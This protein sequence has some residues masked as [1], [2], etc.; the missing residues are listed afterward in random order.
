MKFTIENIGKIKSATIEVKGLTIITGENSIG[1]SVIGKTIF[2]LVKSVTG[3]IE[4]FEDERYSEIYDILR[5]IESIFFSYQRKN[6]DKRILRR[7]INVHNVMRRFEQMNSK[8]P[9]PSLF[10]DKNYAL[11]PFLDYLTET[12]DKFLSSI[13][14]NEENII[15]EVKSDFNKIREIVKRPSDE[16]RMLKGSFNHLIQH[17]FNNEFGNK[18]NKEAR[19]NLI[20]SENDRELVRIEVKNNKTCIFKTESLIFLEDATIIE[21]PIIISLSKF[22]TNNL[23]FNRPQKIT[24]RR[25]IYQDLPYYIFDILQ[26]ISQSTNISLNE[27]L[28][29]IIE[30][31]ISG[32]VTYNKRRD[33][34]IF[35][36]KNKNKYDIINVASG[37]KSFGL[38]QLLLTSDCLNE[39][40]ILI[41]DEPEVHLHP[42]WQLEYAKLLIELVKMQIPIILTSHSP[43]FIEALKV[44]SDKEIPNKTKF[45]LGKMQEKGS[46]FKDVTND[47]EPIFELLAIPM[48]QLIIEK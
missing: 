9:I 3:T 45:Y 33:N 5:N 21:T 15:S 44:Y 37:I 20:F 40:T 6:K 36:D 8:S 12:E 27:D 23:A 25:S 39:N 4:R 47:L 46:V 11:H 31:I 26:K 18:L 43:Y 7:L 1:K 16:E 48:Q 34:F 22:V 13:D 32:K 29:R 14:V 19:A 24:R 38:L 17:V 41:I 28:Y 42:L 35:S 10:T 2:S 30:K